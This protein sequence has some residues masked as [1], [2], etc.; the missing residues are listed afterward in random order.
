MSAELVETSR[1]WARVNAARSSRSG[2][3]RWPRTW[4]S[5]AT[6]SRTGRSKRAAADGHEKV[7]LL[8]PADRRRP[9]GRLRPDRPGAVAASCSSGTRWSRATGTPTTGSSPPTASCSTTSRSSRTGPAGAT[10]SSTTRPSSRSTTR[11][12]RPTWSPAGTSTPGG[13]RPAARSPTCST[14][15]EEML[16]N[17][18]AAT[19]STAAPTRT[20]G[21]RAGSSCRCPTQFEPGTRRRRRHR[22]RAARRCSTRSTRRLRLAGARACARSSSPR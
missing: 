2:P 16:V 5:A 10:S 14:F 8:R 21:W 18:Q 22:R 7:T 12:S 15:T 13:R 6:A 9:Q 3:S 1:L 19:A 17:A 11:A 20:P 4:S